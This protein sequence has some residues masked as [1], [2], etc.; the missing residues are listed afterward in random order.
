MHLL[1]IPYTHTLSHISR[2]LAVAIEL[3]KRGH[4]VTFAGSGDKI[5]FIEEEGFEVL[6]L[7]EPDPGQLFGN[8]RSGKL[9]FVD[10]GEIRTMYRADLELFARVAP[11][12]VLTDG[13]FSA[14]LSTHTAGLRHGAIV[15][16]SSTEYRAL[17]YIPFFQWIPQGIAP[18]GSRFRALLDAMNLKLEMAVF[19]G[20]MNIFTRMSSEIGARHRV[21]ATNCLAG[22]DLTLL[23][24]IPEYFPT[25]DLP[26]D[27][28]Y[29][30]PITFRQRVPNP[31]WWPPD[32]G[33]KPLV[34][35]TMGTTGISNFFNIVQDL[36]PS[37]DF[38]AIVTTGG[39]GKNLVTKEGSIYFEEFLDGDMVMEVCDLV[40]CHGGNGTI[41]QA[42]HHGKPVIGLPTIPDQAFN[43]R[44]VEA[45]GCG[46]TLTWDA[47]ASNPAVLIDLIKE[48]KGNKSFSNNAN[49]LKESISAYDAPNTAADLIEGL[50]QT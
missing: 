18:Q 21:T 41:Y 6:P 8:I 35:I 17:P 47:F 10:D 39:Q 44:R 49:H 11:D 20:T 26:T 40:V 33:T 7:H 36:F 43:M 25:K 4:R 32:V 28:H 45:L 13:R 15:N 31:P 30:G 9:R 34:Y 3:R 48:V 24:D 1:A 2:P 37:S 27:Y 19:D 16:V 12:F 46:K 5:R 42:L 38:A 22:K 23:A 29:I 50:L 14:P